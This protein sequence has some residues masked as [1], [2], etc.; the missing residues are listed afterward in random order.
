MRGTQLP[1]HIA[2]SNEGPDDRSLLPNQES[3]APCVVY[4]LLL[5]ARL[6]CLSMYPCLKLALAGAPG[7]F[8][9]G[10][11]VESLW[12]LCKRRSLCHARDTL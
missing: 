5:C 8:R 7:G 2:C 6:C 9:V 11:S 4:T 10:G 3:S 1:L 12:L